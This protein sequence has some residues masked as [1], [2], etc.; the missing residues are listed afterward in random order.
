MTKLGIVNNNEQG[1]EV[2]GVTIEI[3]NL[4]EPT[5]DNTT[6]VICKDDNATINYEC[7]RCFSTKLCTN[8][9]VSLMEQGYTNC[10]VCQ[11]TSPWCRDISS[12]EI[13]EITP[14][15]QNQSN[16]ISNRV[17]PLPARRI[18]DD[19]RNHQLKKYCY[20]LAN[21]LCIGIGS[22]ILGLITRLILG[23]CVFTCEHPAIDIFHSMIIG[24]LILTCV[25]I[26][27]LCCGICCIGVA[28]LGTSEND[29]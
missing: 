7:L 8:C 17:T 19:R 3:P 11:K 20:H 13:L 26:I 6:C 22:F 5:L 27:S 15:L 4:L 12:K 23:H 14:N 9:S 1:K 16:N 21:I 25:T 29:R 28:T 18:L 10:P 2:L 24:V